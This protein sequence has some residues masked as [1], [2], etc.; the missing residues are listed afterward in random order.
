[1]S[2]LHR[3]L[4]YERQIA[5]SVSAVILPTEICATFAI[6]ATCQ[7]REP[8]PLANAET[9]EQATLEHVEAIRSAGPTAEELERARRSLLLAHHDSRQDLALCADRLSCAATYF[10]D[11]SRIFTEPERL[12]KVDAEQVQDLAR[13]ALGPE[14]R[15]AIIVVPEA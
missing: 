1:M 9:L 8:D 15:A 4:V 12:L 10:G 11:P 3:D 6:I 14:R 13:R 7:N 2:R 5:Q